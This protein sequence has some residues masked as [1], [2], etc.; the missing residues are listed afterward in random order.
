MSEFEWQDA[1]NVGH[2]EL[3]SDHRKFFELL[4]DCYKHSCVPGTGRIDPEFLRKIK[5]YAAMHFSYEEEV[6]RAIG[7]PG[8]EYHE[9]QHRYFE[10]H[11]AEFEKNN[12]G[13]EEFVSMFS[14]LLTW[15]QKHIIEEDRKYAPYL[16]SRNEKLRNEYLSKSTR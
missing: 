5:A 12:D 13:D 14:F 10:E 16:K 9:K 3:D 2:K 4:Q 15:F 1:Y 8:Y 11:I 7:Y 6:L